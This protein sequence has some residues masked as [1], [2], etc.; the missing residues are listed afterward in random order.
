MSANTDGKLSRFL[1]GCLFY[2]GLVCLVVLIF[3]TW[4][5]YINGLTF[6]FGEKTVSDGGAFGDTYGSLNTLFSGLAFAA[7]VVTLFLQKSEL[8]AQREELRDTREVLKLQT[9]ELRDSVRA[10][11]DQTDALEKNRQLQAQPL[12][13]ILS[14]NFRCDDI[15]IH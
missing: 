11:Q 4:R 15:K 5:Y 9:K 10:T 2:G 13:M 12:P 8:A 3:L 14:L 6:L 1:K 7:L